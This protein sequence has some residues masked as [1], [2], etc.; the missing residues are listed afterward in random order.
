L[1]GYALARLDFPGRKAIFAFVVATL[2]VPGI[3]LAVPRFLVLRQLGML[4]SLSG[5][6]VPLAV[7][8][9]GMLLM[10][11]FFESMPRE[12]E[13]AAKVD[14]ASVFATWWR[15]VQGV[16]ASGVKR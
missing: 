2:A 6:I 12:M 13:Q 8:A 3:V 10:K 1:A 5:L 11:H 9:F 14:G 16:A 7:D 4:N 15:I